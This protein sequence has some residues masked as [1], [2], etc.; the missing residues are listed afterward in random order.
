MTRVCGAGASSCA[1]GRLLTLSALTSLVLLVTKSAT[2]ACAA[3]AGVA[4][5]VIQVNDDGQLQFVDNTS[6]VAITLADIA[7][8]KSQLNGLAIWRA[9]VSTLQSQ[10]TALQSQT[11]G[12]QSQTTALQSQNSALLSQTASLQSQNSA[13]QSQ[14]ATLITT[15]NYAV[16]V[17][18]TAAMSTLPSQ[19][20]TSANVCTGGSWA[21]SAS[22]GGCHKSTLSGGCASRTFNSFI[23]FTRVRGRMTGFQAGTP[24]A[25][26]GALGVD[27]FRIT[28]TSGEGVWVYAVGIAGN[29]SCGASPSSCPNMPG[30][31][32]APD[33]S[34]YCESGNPTCSTTN[35][36][37]FPTKLF[38]QVP[39]FD[40]TFSSPQAG[41]V[42]SFCFNQ[43][44]SDEDF[45]MDSLYIEVFR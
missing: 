23:P 14:V 17:N 22:S 32:P 5:A 3:D 34:F 7:L 12:L 11:S 6:S 45:F 13:L 30:G 41:I 8:L 1:V 20:N 16:L 29:S 26:N 25:F 18:Y 27:G 2:P 24:D 10:T 43:P 15:T 42:G 36:A 28:T 44:A 4:A 19:Q 35:T 38:T 9:Q 31:N 39:M 37:L 33:S 21:F 40:V